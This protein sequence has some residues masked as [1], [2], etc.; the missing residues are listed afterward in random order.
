MRACSSEYCGGSLCNVIDEQNNTRAGRQNQVA[1]G[2]WG[3]FGQEAEFGSNL[4]KPIA[5]RMLQCGHDVPN[6]VLSNKED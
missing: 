3:S 2:Q 1:P 6:L 5:I 4:K